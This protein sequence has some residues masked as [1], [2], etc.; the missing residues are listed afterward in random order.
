MRRLLGVAF[1]TWG[2]GGNTVAERPEP[3]EPGG[4]VP[5]A[6]PTHASAPAAETRALALGSRHSCRID[7]EARLWCWGDNWQGQLG[8]GTAGHG[9]QSD[10]RT[11]PTLVS[12]LAEVARADASAHHTCAVTRDARLHCWGFNGEGELGQGKVTGLEEDPADLLPRSVSGL[13]PVREVAAGNGFSCALLESGS[14]RCWGTNY[15]GQLG[16]GFAS[17]E[18]SPSPL[19]VVGLSAESLFAGWDYTCALRASGTLACWGAGEQLG[20]GAALEKATS[21]VNVSLNDVTYAAAGVNHACAL[22]SD[23]K[24]WCWG[25]GSDGQLGVATA[26]E[27]VLLAPVLVPVSGVK[28]LAL[29]FAHSCALDA[30]GSVSCWGRNDWGQLGVGA[31]VDKTT[32]PLGVALP[33][34]IVELAAGWDHSCALGESGALY[35]WGAND[36][37]QLGQGTLGGSIALPAEVFFD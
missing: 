36:R 32:A 37:G 2:C 34:R 22:T 25:R 6:D 31:L 14:A 19:D 29:G 5:P 11:T 26:S 16:A 23:G 24:L 27:E 9:K 12:G 1:L 30:A 8:T 13:E 35:C 7:A 33:E 10:E 15:A 28:A 3:P 18:D 20:T 17:L 4:V 21:P